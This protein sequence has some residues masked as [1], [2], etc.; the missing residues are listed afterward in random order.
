[1]KISTRIG[2]MIVL[3]LLVAGLAFGSGDGESSSSS[4]GS[5]TA[6]GDTS[7]LEEME[8]PM[9][10]AR[11][12]NGELPP[13]EERLP[14]KP[15]VV[16]SGTLLTTDSVDMIP[17]KYGGTLRLAQQGTGGDPI[18]FI[19]MTEPMLWAPNG[20]KFEEGI[21]GN[22]AE[23]YSVNDDNTEFTLKLREGIRWSDGVPVTTEDVAFAY[24]I[25]QNEQLTPSFPNWLKTGGVASGDPAV[26]AIVD[27]YTFTIKFTKPY[28]GFMARLIIAGWTGHSA[29]LIPSHY[30][31]QFHIDYASKEELAKM[32]ADESIDGTVEEGWYNLF[33]EHLDHNGWDWNVT[34]DVAIGMPVLTPWTMVSATEEVWTYERN[35]YYWKVDEEG[36]QLPYIDK[37]QAR[38]APDKEVLTMNGLLGEYDFLGERASLK[39]LSLFKE[40]EKSEGKVQVLVSQFHVASDV[41]FL[42][43]NY[44]DPAWQDAIGNYKFRLA[45]VNAIDYEEI[46]ETF[47]LGFGQVPQIIPAKY[48]TDEANR[49]LD[50]IGMD[51]RDSDGF[52][53]G[54]DGKRFIIPI[55]AAPRTEEMLEVT[56]LAAEYLNEVGLKTTMKQED[57][58]LIGERA[59]ANELQATVLWLAENLWDSGGW[60]DYL[61]N[62]YVAPA[63]NIWI[64]QGPDAEGAIEPPP[65]LLELYDLKAEF[66]SA[67]LGSE[68]SNEIMKRIRQNVYD[69]I[70]Y[71][72]MI[73]RN[74]IPTFW[75]ANMRNVPTGG[76]Y[77]DYQIIADYTMETWF[78]D[79]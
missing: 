40:K 38:Y 55:S 46:L 70:W 29:F 49:L 4:A 18:I 42:N 17:G 23:T 60:D 45:L 12:A 58:S 3:A 20:Y 8:S 57:P 11:V 26:F 2:T 1:M 6:T 53:L 14:N 79:E 48:D 31:K 30:A 28:G 19:G 32:M 22:L 76:R 15:M 59:N 35:P 7:Y 61:P 25:H 71:I 47:F 78:Y 34:Q 27:K 44:P 72:P 16:K 39:S 43:R 68:E 77:D 74:Y 10:A 51:K 64:N 37:I 62:T 52:R 33:N 66:S 50:E 9:L 65:E 24:E 56:Q 36:R 5:N 54:S 13:L 69:N 67:L 73:E 41:L 75:S 21:I 63:W